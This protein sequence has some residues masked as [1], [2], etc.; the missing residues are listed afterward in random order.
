MDGEKWWI[1][2]MFRKNPQAFG[3]KFSGRVKDKL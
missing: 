1:L 3:D 2:E